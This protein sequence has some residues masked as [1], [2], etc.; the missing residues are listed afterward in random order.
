MDGFLLRSDP[1][2]GKRSGYSLS[3]PRGACSQERSRDKRVVH[4]RTPIQSWW[5]I[6]EFRTV[7]LESFFGQ[8]H[9]FELHIL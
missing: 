5:V 3:G 9:I 2:S 1:D 6:D 7:Q 4:E 8:D